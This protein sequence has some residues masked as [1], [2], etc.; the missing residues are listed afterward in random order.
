MYKNFI[1]KYD[2]LPEEAS[3]ERRKIVSLELNMKKASETV[4]KYEY[5]R[6]RD[7]GKERIMTENGLNQPFSDSPNHTDA[8]QSGAFVASES[9]RDL[10]ENHLQELH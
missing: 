8:T 6:E 5:E 9:V 4:V 7:D 1:D 10:A 2:N 3:L